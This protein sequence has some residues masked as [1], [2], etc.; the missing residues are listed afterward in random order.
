MQL[1]LDVQSGPA[2]GQKAVVTADR[3]FYVGRTEA[4]FLAVRKDWQMDSSHFV[5]ERR[6]DGWLLRDLGTRLGTLVNGKKVSR[7]ELRPGDTITAG[8]STFVVRVEG[9]PALAPPPPVAGPRVVPTTPAPAT[10]APRKEP[11]A[12]GGGPLLEVLQ[13]QPEPLYTILDA[14]RDPAIYLLVQG[15]Q[16]E[17]QSL[18]EGPKGERLALAAP[19]LVRLPSGSPIL[20]TL[21]ERGWGKSW[22]VYLTCRLPFAEVRRHFRKFLLVKDESERQRYFRFYD[23]RVLRVYLPTCTPTETAEFVGPVGRFLMEDEDP[24]T[25]VQFTAGRHGPQRQVQAL[26]V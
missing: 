6:E 14:A 11:T 15:C 13:E 7:A 19:Y 5:L 25:L 1:I 22:G 8:M 9:E 26:A 20:R 2:A 3:P 21:V 4:L 12:E 23:P 18:F 17:K 24:R 16:E 10:V